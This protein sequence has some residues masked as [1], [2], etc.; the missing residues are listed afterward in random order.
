MYEA[1]T[2]QT[3]ERGSS[4]DSASVSAF[5]SLPV[6]E[7]LQ[8]DPSGVLFE[9]HSISLLVQSRSSSN[10]SSLTSPR[11]ICPYIEYCVRSLNQL[12]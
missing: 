9:D 2:E 7:V 4:I 8:D 10:L 6:L 5:P 1:L 3:N 11:G 12:A